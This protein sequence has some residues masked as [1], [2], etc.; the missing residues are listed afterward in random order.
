MT[1]ADHTG[2]I[3]FLW[4][5][6]HGRKIRLLLALA[7]LTFVTLASLVYPWLLKLMVDRFSGRGPSGMSVDTLCLVLLAVFAASSLIGYFQQKEMRLL[8]SRLRNSVRISL[9]ESLLSRPMEFH[10]ASRVGELS[11]RATEDVGKLQVAFSG[12]LSPL[13]QNTLFVAG[14][15]VL[16]AVLN[17]VATLLVIALVALPV[18][19]LDALSRRIRRL[20]AESRADHAAANAFLAETLVAIREIKAF[21]REKLEVARYALLLDSALATE[22]RLTKLQG[23]ADQAV[24]LL[25]SGALLGIFYAGTRQ[26]FFPAWSIGDVIA[27]YFYSYT[28]T[29]A[30]LSIGRTYFAYQEFSG[31]LGRVRDLFVGDQT[32]GTHSGPIAGGV[33][34]RSVAFS[35]DHLRPVLT[36]VSFSLQPGRWLLVTGTSGSGK[37]TMASLLPRFIQPEAGSIIVDGVELGSWNAVTLRRQIGYVGQDPM[38]LSG[39]LRENIL[40]ADLHA[41]EEQLVRAVRVS[42]LDDLVES[43]PRGLETPVGERGYTLSS[44]QKARVAIARAIVHDPPILILDEANSALEPELERRLWANLAEDRG[45][46]TTIIFSHHTENI[47]GNCA[48][49]RLCEGTLLPLAREVE[50]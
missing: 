12:I 20:S 32:T 19:L 1:R 45:G 4:K 39:T 50:P 43:L 37:S 42:C 6:L 47:H 41:S 48:A 3:R 25:F 15:L 28:M 21:V 17:W 16:M 36:N 31:S 40:F 49:A 5:F 2:G 34:F 38:L 24:Y 26:T 30:I 8:G 14:C 44:G 35:Y 18:P 27:F 7:G 46:K 13:F 29:M 33:E 22:V 11:S 10:R 23:K 9:Y